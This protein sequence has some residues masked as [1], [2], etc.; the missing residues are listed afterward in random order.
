MA[1]LLIALGVIVVMAMGVGCIVLELQLAKRA[2]AAR[3]M[4]SWL[5]WGVT[6]W[7]G[8]CLLIWASGGGIGG[9]LGW[10]FLIGFVGYPMVR[11][12]FAADD[13]SAKASRRY[14]EELKR[15]RYKATDFG[16]TA[17]PK[18]ADAI[19]RGAKTAPAAP[20]VTMTPLTPLPAH[21]VLAEVSAD[22]RPL[23]ARATEQGFLALVIAAGI[24]LLLIFSVINRRDRYEPRDMAAAEA[25]VAETLEM[26]GFAAPKLTRQW[27][28]IHCKYNSAAYRWSA[29]GAE[30]RACACF[31]DGEITVKVDRSWG[32]LPM[33]FEPMGAPAPTAEGTP[34]PPAR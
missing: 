12:R 25:A 19:R 26:N 8:A 32:R 34:G 20:A 13:W 31:D 15:L 23:W 14:A 2:H 30:G 27:L 24:A 22:K 33:P 4:L 21:S 3:F 11:A 29:M 7:Q 5:A 28:T 1:G 17:A 16:G 10:G 18:T 6:S 9:G